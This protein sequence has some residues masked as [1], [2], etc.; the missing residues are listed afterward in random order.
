MKKIFSIFIV[1]IIVINFSSPII[2]AV[3][4]NKN[5]II[6]ESQEDKNKITNITNNIE[7]QTEEG[8]YNENNE[9]STIIEDNTEELNNDVQTFSSE[10][11]I[12]KEKSQARMWIDEPTSNYISGK[13]VNVAGWFLSNNK[14]AILKIYIDGK[15]TNTIIARVERED[16]LSA[17]SGYGGRALNPRPGFVATID[18][19]NV[20]YGSHTIK[21][22]VL[23]SNGVEIQKVE[24]NVNIDNRTQ[25]RMYLDMP[26]GN[27][28]DGNNVNIAGWFLC[29]DKKAT[30][31]I[32]IDG[33]DTNTDISRVE[34]EDVLKAVPGYGGRVSNPKPGFTATL[35]L[36][37]VTYGN[38][39]IKYVVLDENGIELQKVEKTVTIDNR[40]KAKMCVDEPSGNYIDGKIANVAGWFLCSDTSAKLK[41]Y[42]DGKDTNTDI[43]RV[44]REDVL[45]AVPGYGGRVSN[46]KPG[47]TA[48]LDL[49]KVTYGN[50]T[51]KYVVLDGNGI[52]L[53][54]VEKTVTIDNRT[55]ARMC[56][57]EPSG[58]YIEGNTLNINGWYLCNVKSNIKLYIDNEEKKIY[59]PR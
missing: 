1:I 58:N 15:D 56:V 34:R 3:N 25:A 39:T 59:I 16:V 45:R 21:Y 44:E 10:N 32:Y 51:I 18:L 26:T 4:E 30:L 53:Q 11:E 19:S 7:S 14:N 35:D 6:N 20:T 5:T 9:E 41:I 13:N 57:D 2:F 46:P 43:S 22:A 17:I 38:H 33:K 36:S 50:H 42:I 31:K 40:T 23:D 49:S 37:K 28:I 48:T 12:I 54:K 55:K 8:T 52:E 29:S 27:Y 47:F 24:K